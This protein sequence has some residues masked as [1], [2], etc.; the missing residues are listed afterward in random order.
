MSKA[1]DINQWLLRRYW[2]L[3]SDSPANQT[4][5][6]LS[7]L[8]FP[9]NPTESSLPLGTSANPVLPRMRA[10]MTTVIKISPFNGGNTDKT[11]CVDE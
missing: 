5:L 9:A 11:E 4:S 7:P 2:E 3:S 1:I 6:F 8:A 10:N